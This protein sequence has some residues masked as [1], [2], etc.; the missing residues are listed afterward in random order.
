MQVD[1]PNLAKMVA[2]MPAAFE[3]CTWVHRR[4]EMRTRPDEAR[5]GLIEGECN[6][7][8]DLS[9]AGMG[10][11]KASSRKLQ[12]IFPENEGSSIATISYPSEKASR[13]EP[14]FEE[15][16]VKA[17]GVA[18]RVPPPPSWHYVAWGAAGL[19]L[20]WLLAKVIV[21]GNEP[22]KERAKERAK[23]PAKDDE[24]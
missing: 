14:V 13:W 23:E 16:I 5:V 17:K 18:I 11:I 24:E 21:R 12:L 2:E 1:E 9:A 19:G 8:I 20:G 15:T 7:E 4:H 3:E 22:A 6:R 10:N